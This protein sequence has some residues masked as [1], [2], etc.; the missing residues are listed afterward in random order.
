[1]CKQDDSSLIVIK[2]DKKEV[3]PLIEEASINDLLD[4]LSPYTTKMIDWSK[5][6]LDPTII[7]FDENGEREVKAKS[8]LVTPYIGPSLIDLLIKV[9]QRRNLKPSW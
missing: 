5:D 9:N 2:I 4:P 6:L 8:F 1:L 7:L 3:T